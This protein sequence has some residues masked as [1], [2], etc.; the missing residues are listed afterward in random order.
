M[1]RVFSAML[2]AVAFA[3]VF[4][5]ELVEPGDWR[6]TFLVATAAL[7][8]FA[9]LGG[10]VGRIAERWQLT[11]LHTQLFHRLKGTSGRK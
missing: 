6:S 10:L 8:G 3:A 11:S 1:S 7:V 4:S 2:G 5:R 9:V